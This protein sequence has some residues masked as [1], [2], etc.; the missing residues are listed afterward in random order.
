MPFNKKKT[1]KKEEVSL[2]EALGFDSKRAIEIV[3]LVDEAK[4][5]TDKVSDALLYLHERLDDN[6]LL[7]AC[8]VLGAKRV[9]DSLE[10][11]MADGCENCEDT[12]LLKSIKKAIKESMGK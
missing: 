11:C 9:I 6:E 2:P 10:E 8:H 1:V 5:K 4:D 3:D 12:N 7:F